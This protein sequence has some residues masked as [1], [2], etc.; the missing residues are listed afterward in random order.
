MTIDLMKDERQTHIDKAGTGRPVRGSRTW[1]TRSL[2][3]V[4]NR[5]DWA[6][7]EAE[8]PTSRIR[9]TGSSRRL[10]WAT[11]T[12]HPWPFPLPMATTCPPMLS[13]AASIPAERRAGRA[14]NGLEAHDLRGGRGGI[15]REHPAGLRVG[16]RSLVVTPE[17]AQLGPELV[18]LRH[19][20]EAPHE[21]VK[22]TFGNLVAARLRVSLPVE[23]S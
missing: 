3:R 17:H 22:D 11:G 10:G 23:P 2:P 1:P 20:W 8:P 14:Y 6:L 4:T 9:V 18:T 5:W 15:R 13:R 19:L 12:I 21:V 7:V 16:Q